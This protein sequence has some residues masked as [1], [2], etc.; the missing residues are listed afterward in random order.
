MVFLTSIPY[1]SQA[2]TCRLQ[3]DKLAFLRVLAA[4]CCDLKGAAGAY[5]AIKAPSPGP[6]PNAR[7]AGSLSVMGSSPCKSAFRAW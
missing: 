7:E 4:Q 5:R 3:F 2:N 6:T 1:S